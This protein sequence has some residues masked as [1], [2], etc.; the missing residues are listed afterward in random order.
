M[1]TREQYI[2][3]LAKMRRNI[4]LNGELIDR[5]DELQMD[6]INTIG[7]TFNEAAR[8]ENEALCT[9]IS[10]LSGERISRFTHIHQNT[11]DLH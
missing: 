11:D 8:P 6:C 1:R 3:G 2:Q 5:T 7:T 4:Y 9:A 10:H